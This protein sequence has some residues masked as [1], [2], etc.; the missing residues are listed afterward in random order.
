MSKIKTDFILR[1]VDIAYKIFNFERK[2]NFQLHL[3]YFY[4]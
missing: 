2:K 4:T 1:N 3:D